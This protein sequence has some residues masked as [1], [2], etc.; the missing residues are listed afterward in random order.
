MRPRWVRARKREG[1]PK[2]EG[3]ESGPDWQLHLEESISQPDR[4]QLEAGPV[5]EPAPPVRQVEGPAVPGTD[6]E[7]AVQAAHGQIGP[8]VG[9]AIPASHQ[10][11]LDVEDRNRQ[12]R[13]DVPADLP[14]G[15]IR[16][17][18]QNEESFR[19]FRFGFRAVFRKV[20]DVVDAHAASTVSGPGEDEY[21][22][23]PGEGRAVRASGLHGPTVETRLEEGG[24][25]V[26]RAQLRPIREPE[27]DDL[28]GIP[29]LGYRHDVAARPRHRFPPEQRRD[30]LEV[31]I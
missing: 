30:S 15:D 4:I 18:P 10:A 2:R 21:G 13:N 25:R 20:P 9:A 24:F 26:G 17:P 19:S 28:G 27:Q 12:A 5:L 11:T 22:L 6:D 7:V 31:P 1:N 23:S 16:R 3:P 14:C 8:H 29:P